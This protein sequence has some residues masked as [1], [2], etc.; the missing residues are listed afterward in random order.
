MNEAEFQAIVGEYATALAEAVD[1]CANV[2][3]KRQ[4]EATINPLHRER[5][6]VLLGLSSRLWRLTKYMV[7]NPML[8]EETRAAAEMR[9]IVDTVITSRWLLTQGDERFAAFVAYGRGQ[10][11][12][13]CPIFCV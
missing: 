8:W 9:A 10:L 11:K 3:R 2:L 12:R 1:A 13:D 4:F 6:E 7:S 5:N